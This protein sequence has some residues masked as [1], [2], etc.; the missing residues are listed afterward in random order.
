MKNIKVRASRYSKLFW[1]KWNHN[2]EDISYNIGLAYDITGD[3]NILKLK[4]SLKK[5]IE[6]NIVFRSSFI[7]NKTGELFQ[8][9][10]DSI[11]ESLY[12]EEVTLENGSE[13]E[14]KSLFFE[15]DN[16]KFNL[17]KPPLLKFYIVKVSKSRHILI[18][19]FHHIIVDGT[20]GMSVPK[21]IEYFYSSDEISIDKEG[22][23]FFN[24][25][26]YEQSRFKK[27]NF[28]KTFTYWNNILNDNTLSVQL[29]P[30]PLIKKMESSN[31]IDEFCFVLGDHQTLKLKEFCTENS[32]FPFH[33]LTAVWSMLLSR[34]TG[35]NSIPLSF[36]INLKPKKD[37]QLIACLVNVLPLILTIHEEDD[38]LSFSKNVAKQIRTSFRYREV[39]FSEMIT[40]Y[41]KKNKNIIDTN[42]FNIGINGV[43]SRTIPLKLKN[44]PD[45]P[46][47]QS[48]A[49]ADYDLNLEFQVLD[50]QTKLQFNY[51]TELYSLNFIDKLSLHF[52]NLLNDILIEPSKQL[53]EYSIFNKEEYNSIIHGK[54]DIFIDYPREK[55]IQQFFE[56]QVEKTPDELAIV[57]EN[58]YLT[59]NELNEKTNQ[60]AH[61]I[62]TEYYEHFNEE[63]N[64]DT[65]IGVYFDR[66]FDMIIAILAIIKSGAAYVPFDLHDP[67]ERL[68][69]KVNDSKVKLVLT[70]LDNVQNLVFLMYEDALPMSIDTYTDEIEKSPKFNPVHFNKPTDLAYVIYTSGSTGTPKG[71]MQQHRTITNLVYY[72]KNKCN[73][74]FASNVL[75][76][77][78]STFDVS[79]QEIFSTL[80]NG[81]T[82]Y[83]ITEEVRRNVIYLID[84]IIANRIE[85]LLCPPAILNM[86]FNTKELS[87]KLCACSL[88]HIIA[89]GDKLL[90]GDNLRNII[91]R[92]QIKLHNHYGP[93]ETH[94]T[95]TFTIEPEDI[96]KWLYP[97]IG[98]AVSNH[99]L[100]ILDSKLRP[101]PIGMPGELYVG[102]EGVARGYL[103]RDLLTKERFI[104]N[105]FV[106]DDEIKNSR[107][108]NL[109]K[110]GDIVYQLQDGNLEYIERNDFQVK[111][112]G[113]RIEMGEI[114]DKLQRNSEIKECIVTVYK[115]KIIHN[116]QLV[117]YYVTTDN[118]VFTPK[119]L[120][121]T[122]ELLRKY[123]ADILPY[124]MIPTYFVE[125]KKF[126]LTNNGK[127]DR[128]K[129]PVP[130]KKVNQIENMHN[131]HTDYNNIRGELQEIWKSVLGIHE[132]GLNDKFFEIGGN[133]ILSIQLMEEINREY[134][135]NAPNY[136]IYNFQTIESQAKELG[137]GLFSPHCPFIFFNKSESKDILILIH[138]TGAGAEVYHQLVQYLDNERFNIIGVNSYNINNQQSPTPDLKLIAG[139]YTRELMK[140][141]DF[142]DS[143]L[144]VGG[145][146]S[147]G[148]IAYEMVKVFKEKQLSVQKLFL[149]DSFNFSSVHV[150]EELDFNWQQR[151]TEKQLFNAGVPDNLIKKMKKIISLETTGLESLVHLPMDT[152]ITL[153]KC[154][155]ARPYDEL[156]KMSEKEK[157]ESDKINRL[158]ME[159]K[160]NGWDEIVKNLDV[161]NLPSH[162]G[163]IVTSI[164]SINLI[165]DSINKVL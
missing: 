152:K 4:F 110:T 84:F 63:I 8:H 44:L 64:S 20:S 6:K 112:R 14:L 85:I 159:F 65:L 106:T 77:T 109:Y 86:I 129:L 52:T 89:A 45:A 139:Y 145:W 143:K 82:L 9:F 131:Q 57:F 22:N 160:K 10:V 34:Y 11:D 140:K 26:E 99:T 42:M 71:V 81:G 114:E 24:Y 66:S 158:I 120:Q 28:D 32:L 80:F 105:P 18:L 75:Q 78:S 100:Y 51:C 46:L 39:P 96:S 31:S 48:Q 135:L 161:I 165:S 47:I 111:I 102:G 98:K 38:F 60:L 23:D 40:E 15:A 119:R 104:K 101:V 132:V 123:L 91:S 58:T 122:A 59:Y 125:L 157:N 134:E 30:K 74:N 117:A 156:I 1:N 126:P 61:T 92:K 97:P 56:E 162:H 3:L 113:F 12:L 108:L 93:T 19:R 164:D 146:S 88:K 155:E 138:P 103:C 124:Y 107:N 127:I 149:F 17:S 49:L 62:R 54:N 50:T 150:G 68:K 29:T 55:T 121:L 116:K 154:M 94:V 133:S 153:F 73:I 67:E 142:N 2:K 37:V 115:N 69:S 16:F 90:V 13:D 130:S 53:S 79:V 151:F 33:V 83:L 27:I 163:N 36:P 118:S 41:Y 25:L 128:A 5:L 95:T 137:K 76:F 136:F 87:D 35:K 141:I 147:G 21:E 148:N 70:I 43:E 144:Y 72:Q 7:E